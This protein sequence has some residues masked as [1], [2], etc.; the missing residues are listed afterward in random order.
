M[1]ATMNARN[2][3]LFALLTLLSAC[4]RDDD[5]GADTTPVAQDSIAEV[6]PPIIAPDEAAD[7]AQ[8][9]SY[10]VSIASAASQHNKALERCARQ[11][12]A[13]RTQCE[14]E[15]NAAFVEVETGLEP[16]RG[17]PE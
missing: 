10:E 4:A 12:E 1:K 11:P 9:P 3:C 13:V 5:A 15:A 2:G 8:P 7:P 17:N 6:A 14:Q 16:L